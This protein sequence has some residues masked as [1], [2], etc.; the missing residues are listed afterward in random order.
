MPGCRKVAGLF[1]VRCQG[2]DVGEVAVQLSVVRHKA[3]FVDQRADE[4]ERFISRVVV[5]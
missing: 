4:F 1:S 3:D 5:I 2:K